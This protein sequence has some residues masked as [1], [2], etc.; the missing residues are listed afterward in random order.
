[1]TKASV[2]KADV[3]VV[4]GVE[5]STKKSKNTTIAYFPTQSALSSLPTSYWIAGERSDT[6]ASAKQ[7]GWSDIGPDLSISQKFTN[8]ISIFREVISWDGDR[9]KQGKSCPRS[10]ISCATDLD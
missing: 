9:G 7:L 1:M 6:P 8:D 3:E 2:V 4:S 5:L 10:G